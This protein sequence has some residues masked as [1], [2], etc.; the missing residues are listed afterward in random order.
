MSYFK[1]FYKLHNESLGAEFEGL[2][3]KEE[4]Q[5]YDKI[6]LNLDISVWYRSQEPLAEPKS[7]HSVE[8]FYYKSKSEQARKTFI[9][10]WDFDEW[11]KG[12]EYKTKETLL[13][14]YYS[15]AE[16][17]MTL[18][19]NLFY[20]ERTIQDDINKG[21]EELMHSL[22]PNS[23]QFISNRKNNTFNFLVP[24]S[25]NRL[26]CTE[27]P[28]TYNAITFIGVNDKGTLNVGDV[29]LVEKATINGIKKTKED[30][31]DGTEMHSPK[32]RESL[33][34]SFIKAAPQEK[35]E[36]IL[37][38]VRKKTDFFSDYWYTTKLKK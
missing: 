23:N 2:G 10:D 1:N 38:S 35:I 20:L 5:P 17:P 27:Y 24:P 15:E 6:I 36:L 37:N 25:V 28:I 21:V 31:M 8:S 13:K 14:N 7:T 34:N 32:V 33:F 18:D 9:I 26:I 3:T 22:G 30:E 4:L 19:S 16:P 12:L 11:R 29:I